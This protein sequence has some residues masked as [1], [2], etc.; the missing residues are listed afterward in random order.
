LISAGK[1]AALSLDTRHFLMPK[2]GFEMSE[3]ED[4]IAID[5]TRHR[6]AI[7]DGA[8]EAFAAQNWARQLAINW[9]DS[10]SPI[11]CVDEFRSWAAE[12]GR[13]LHDSWSGLDLAWYS[14]EKARNGSF[15]AFAGVQLELAGDVP[16]WEAIAL[17]DTCI[18]QL[19]NGRLVQALPVSS[20][21]S[22]NATP[23]LVPSHR[24]LL[25]AAC[26]HVAVG[27]GTVEH[28]DFLLLLSDAVAAWLFML[29]EN[30]ES[31]AYFERLLRGNDREL[32]ALFT[33]QRHAGRLRDDDIAVI[34]IEALNRELS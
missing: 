30:G 5:P 18:V 12:Q 17:G 33:D 28:G 31:G 34:S 2:N 10:D 14:E 16:S 3:C 29:F 7:A 19:R 20:S 13:L 4:V 32:A 25:G 21:D 1:T 9:V 23:W 8:T 26:E 6:F 15:A 11:L 22:F 24:L 27:R